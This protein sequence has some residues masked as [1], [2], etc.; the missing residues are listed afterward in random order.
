MTVCAVDGV[1]VAE[2]RSGRLVHVDELPRGTENHDIVEVSAEAFRAGRDSRS[3][4]RAA[5]EDMLLHHDS[6]HPSSACEFS[7]RL[8]RALRA[9]SV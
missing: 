3:D 8:H 9:S 4:L 7:D 1:E 2:S 5:I 6:M